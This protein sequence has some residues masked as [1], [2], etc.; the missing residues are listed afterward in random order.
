MARELVPPYLRVAADL[1]EKI[2]NGELLPGEQVPSLDRLAE[3]YSVS[4]TTAR[5]AVQVL[6]SEGLVVSRPRWG[7]FVTERH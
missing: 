5:R 2:T 7:V 3:T 1:R 4:R 6:I